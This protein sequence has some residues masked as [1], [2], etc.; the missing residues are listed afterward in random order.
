MSDETEIKPEKYFSKIQINTDKYNVHDKGARDDIQEILAGKLDEHF[1]DI[2]QNGKF[3][4]EMEVSGSY[5]LLTTIRST[6][7]ALISDVL[8]EFKNPIK[9]ENDSFD[10]ENRGTGIYII[11]WE[12]N[13]YPET[14]EKTILVRFKHNNILDLLVIGN[15]LYYRVNS[16]G[17]EEFVNLNKLKEYSYSKI[18]SDIKLTEGIDASEHKMH[19][20]YVTLLTNAFNNLGL[21]I[22]TNFTIGTETKSGTYL[23]HRDEANPLDD[24][25]TISDEYTINLKS[26]NSEKRIKLGTIKDYSANRDNPKIFENELLIDGIRYLNENNL[27]NLINQIN[28]AN[29]LELSKEDFYLIFKQEP[30]ISEEE[31]RQNILN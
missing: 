23:S 7:S 12:E 31:I 29:K 28:L 10:A 18:D 20:E 15:K 8:K 13:K 30:T 16:Y 21:N 5:A 25:K 3:T 6:L 17:W 11:N 4:P 22:N 26:V 27:D 14:F 19:D 2:A 24:N 9:L 1:L